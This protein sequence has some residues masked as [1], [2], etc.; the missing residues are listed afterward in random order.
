MLLHER[1]VVKSMEKQCEMC[2]K[3][4]EC[5]DNRRKYCDECRETRKHY[6][7]RNA[8]QKL[9]ENARMNRLKEQEELAGLRTENEILRE[10]ITRLERLVRLL[11]GGGTN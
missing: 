7:D 6:F 3:P 9:R 8:I 4:I 5:R 1:G 10:E 11:K 2:G